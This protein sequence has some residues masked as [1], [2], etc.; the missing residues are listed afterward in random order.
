MANNNITR[1]L[2]DI[3]KEKDK[4]ELIKILIL[5]NSQLLIQD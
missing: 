5:K 1:P 3:Y 2:E 4:E